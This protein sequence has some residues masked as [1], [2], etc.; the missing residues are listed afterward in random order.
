MRKRAQAWVLLLVL[1]S[2]RWALAE[3]LVDLSGLS[4]EQRALYDAISSER[5]SPCGDAETLQSSLAGGAPC[6]E[7]IARARTLARVLAKDMPRE[8]AESLLDEL[9][10]IAAQPPKTIDLTGVPGRGPE[11]APITL[12][13]VADF[14]CPYCG[15]LEPILQAVLR[16]HPTWVRHYFLNL[17]IT[18]AHLHADAAARAALA[19]GKQ[20]KFWEYHDLLYARQE[21]LS[22]ENF[23]RWAEE[24]GLD[25]ARFQADMASQELRDKVAADT[26][27][28]LK[29]LG[30]KGTP[31][32]FINGRPYADRPTEEAIED[33][34]A[35]AYAQATGD[36]SVYQNDPGRRALGKQREL[37]VVFFD[38]AGTALGLWLLWLFLSRG[39]S[40]RLSSFAKRLRPGP[41]G[42][43]LVYGVL[44]GLGSSLVALPLAVAS[45]WWLDQRFG[46]SN[47]SFG[48][49][50]GEWALGLALSLVAVALLFP[51][52]YFAIRRFGARWWLAAAT[53]VVP[54]TVALVFLAPVVLMPLFNQYTP[55]PDGAVK[56]R[57]EALAASQEIPLE[58]IF[59]MDMSRQTSKANAFVTGLGA[60]KRVVY[61]DT[62]LQKFTPDEIAFVT[63]HEFGHY[64]EHHIWLGIALGGVG[65][66][67]LF[68]LVARLA[69][70][71]IASR[72][73]RFQIAALQD[74]AS[75][76]ALVLVAGLLGL[77]AQP[78]GNAYSRYLEER[79]DAYGI[80]VAPDRAAAASAFEK[81]ATQNLANPSPN[82]LVKYWMY[83][84]P[85]IQ[86]RIEFVLGGER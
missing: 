83:T 13:E 76:P 57:I 63:G 25:A 53:A 33:A 1:F 75:Y 2:A 55:L 67:L 30:V 32:L 68:F 44:Y 28:A 11:N 37:Y 17:P 52:L 3:G 16:R 61:S 9:D 20:G 19:A 40:A 85:P 45:G 7:S 24:L 79:A 34:L 4:P 69:E 39:W 60:T 58:G 86:E 26:D 14:E 78:L 47:Q 74:P 6:P 54:L 35:F 80:A 84:H 21:Q 42:H 8:R 41:W 82:V 59:E 81:L 27:Q 36:Q 77:L 73:A 50:L 22:D 64:A 51:L 72:R 38:L 15:R 18:N 23:L 43:S 49:W 71:L 66:F 31:R 48:A 62:L 46:L 5:L 70:R 10:E 56:T 29:Q 12:V 65:G